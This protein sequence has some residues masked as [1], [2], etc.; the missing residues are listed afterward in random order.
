MQLLFYKML[1]SLI[2]LN[3]FRYSSQA[4]AGLKASGQGREPF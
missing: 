2:S 1:S 4:Y 3:F